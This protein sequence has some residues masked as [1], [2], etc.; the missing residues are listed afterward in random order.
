MTELFEQ[1]QRLSGVE[2]IESETRHKVM[3]SERRRQILTVLAGESKA[4]DLREL[5]ADLVESDP[6]LD[7]DEESAIEQL[8]ASLHHVH[9]PVL[10]ETPILAYDPDE[11]RIEL[12][13]EFNS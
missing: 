3:A 11:K 13:A 6:E 9:L 12:T 1:P 7:R 5:A 10:T 8:A 2:T 4:V